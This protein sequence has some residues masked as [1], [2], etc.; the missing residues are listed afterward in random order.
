MLLEISGLGVNYAG[1]E[2]IRDISI[3]VNEGEIISLVGSNG[4]GKSTTLRAISGLVKPSAG[5]IR[6]ENNRIDGMPPY[7]IVKL[8]VGHVPER[9]D[10]F[11]YMT[12]LENLKLGAFLRKD[13]N[14]I[15]KD[16]EVQFEHFPILG[17]RKRQ[18]ARTM[19]GGEQQMLAIARA[20]MNRPKL[21]LMD[22]PS[23]GLS[24]LMAQ[25]IAQI[26]HDIHK[27]GVSVI[28]VEQNAMMALDLSERGYV[29]ERG[30]II[31]EGDAKELLRDEHVKRAY[32][33]L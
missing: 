9:R 6:L 27:R 8:G 13:K 33:G 19:S 17:E 12:V 1:A 28:L 14:E 2:A 7:T 29:F 23:L 22:E 31:L 15:D 21:L 18:H 32:L 16:L 24:P 25:E 5:E 30:S 26:V 3:E 10:L 11:P 4:A 20:L